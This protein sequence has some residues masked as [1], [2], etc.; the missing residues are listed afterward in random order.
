MDYA[1]VD[2]GRQ[3]R[4]DLA[5]WR[6]L[7][8]SESDPMIKK[9]VLSFLSFAVTL[10]HVIIVPRGRPEVQLVTQ[11]SETGAGGFLKTMIITPL[12]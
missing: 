7:A 6:V 8:G 2:L 11:K 1:H 3:R 5:P 10:C 4:V 9:H 12:I